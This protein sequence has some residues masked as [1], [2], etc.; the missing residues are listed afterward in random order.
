MRMTEKGTRQDCMH[1]E[2]QI[3]TGQT[4]WKIFHLEREG[5]KRNPTGCPQI[6]SIFT[7]SAMQVPKEMRV[8]LQLAAEPGF[9]YVMSV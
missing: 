3:R 4:Y 1:S 8:H 9:D 6:G 7:C 2:H 5:L